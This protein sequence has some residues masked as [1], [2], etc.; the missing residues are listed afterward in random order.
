P[1]QGL[2][3]CQ[4]AFLD[5]ADGGIRIQRRHSDHCPTAFFAVHPAG[6]VHQDAP[7]L[8]R[9]YRKEMGAVSPI[10]ALRPADSNVRFMPHSLCLERVSAMFPAHLPRG[11]GM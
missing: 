2:I 5:S 3:D 11:N 4:Q 9:R 10:D 1:A 7:K 8:L 6:M